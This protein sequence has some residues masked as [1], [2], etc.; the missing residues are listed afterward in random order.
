MSEIQASIWI[1]RMKF[2]GPR[3]AI[4][5][6]GIDSDAFRRSDFIRSGREL[7][8]KYG[9]P[10]DA[11][12]LCCIAGFRPVKLHAVL[13]R[14]MWQLKDAAA[15]RYYLLLAGSGPL[16][17]VLRRQVS[18]LGLEN[19]VFF[20]GEVSDVRPVLAA[21]DCKLLVSEA[22]TFSMAMLEAMAMELPVIATSVGG[23]REAIQNGETGFLVTP[24]DA[25]DL[26]ARIRDTFASAEQREAIGRR[27]RKAV[28]ERF[29][30]SRM[31]TTSAELLDRL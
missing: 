20:L 26:V 5:H 4:I 13:L 28:V 18:E 17:P 19:E 9:I 22:E 1:R 6:N 8:E 15:G 10:G 27:A 25:G 2:L 14:A 16:E 24:G 3:S 21:A 31:I 23:S 12:V 11:R 7:R 29:S 30:R